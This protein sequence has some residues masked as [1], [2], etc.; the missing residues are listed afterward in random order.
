MNI[1]D[2]CFRCLNDFLK[3]N[4]GVSKCHDCDAMYFHTL[5]GNHIFIL[6][7]FINYCDL[8]WDINTKKCFYRQPVLGCSETKIINVGCLP[9]DITIE[10]FKQLL[11]FI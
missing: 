7:N 10:K 8:Y 5:K 9:F 3:V 1:S 4:N 6:Y 2:K 11:M